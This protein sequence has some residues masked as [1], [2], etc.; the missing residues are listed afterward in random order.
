M[1]A[2]FLTSVS[3][4]LV[5][6]SLD[7]SDVSVRWATSWTEV[8][9]TAQVKLWTTRLLIFCQCH[10]QLLRKFFQEAVQIKLDLGRY[11]LSYCIIQ[12]SP[13]LFYALLYFSLST[14]DIPLR[15]GKT[16]QRIPLA[17]MYCALYTVLVR[18]G[19]VLYFSLN[20]FFS[21]SCESCS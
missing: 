21:T 11:R 17:E 7:S 14:S 1:S 4:V 12:D 10:S 20:F 16:D 8:V 13:Y 18:Y 5:I 6:T 15:R 3:T 2:H 19:L 9:V